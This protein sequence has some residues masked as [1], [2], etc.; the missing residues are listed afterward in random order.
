MTQSDSEIPQGVIKADYLNPTPEAP[1][2]HASTIVETESGSLAAAWFAG[3]QEGYP[4]VCIWF[5]RCEDGRWTTPAIVA[6][7]VQ[8]D[9]I[10]YPCWNPVLFQL[11]NGPLMLFYK[12]GPDCAYWWGEL[13]TSA[14]NGH[15]WSDA[16]RLPH[17][18]L[19]PI[20]NKPIELANGEILCPS[21]DEIDGWSVH[22]ER[23]SDM[24]RTWR[25]TERLTDPANFWAIQPSLLRHGSGR[26]Q[27]IGRT[28]GPKKLY[29]IFSDDKG[30]TWT[31]P[32]LLDVPNPN[33]GTDAVTLSNGV[34]L[35]VYNN[36]PD[37]RTPLNI[38]LSEDGL[39]WR[40][41]LTLEDNP[42]EYSYPAVI[43]TSD[44]FV[45]VTYSWRRKMIKHV[46]LDTERLLRVH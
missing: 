12:V 33:A 21:S 9:G 8:A 15:N 7:G 43:Q 32:S 45:H 40:P 27:A 5:T 44:G 4:D 16:H 20:K 37:S 24:G 14:D 35:L 28:N 19:G 3:T 46:V 29:S 30:E 18:I 2:C 23:T 41:V 6:D 39:A 34:H 17:G 13:K 1:A 10:R 22:M 36:T 25:S 38:A 31:A 42:G 11:S 26:L